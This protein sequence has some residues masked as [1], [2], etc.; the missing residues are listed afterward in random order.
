[1]SADRKGELVRRDDECWAEL[2]EL[3]QRLSEEQVVR[4]GY[5]EGWSVKDMLAHLGSWY[6]QTA[7]VLEQ[8]RSGTFVDDLDTEAL[9]LVWYET[10]RDQELRIVLS[11]L[12][13]ARARTLE[14][15]SRLDEITPQADEWFRETSYEHYDEHLPRLREW[16]SELTGSA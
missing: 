13:S 16:V 9:N 2:R 11:E 7:S 5:Y 4:D 15:W 8:M 6:A 12:N 1:V 14:E 3:L 10:W